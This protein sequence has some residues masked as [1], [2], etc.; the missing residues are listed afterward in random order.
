MPGSFE[1]SGSNAGERLLT[2][3]A[4]LPAAEPGQGTVGVRLRGA[5]ASSPGSAPVCGARLAAGAGQNS[6]PAT[7]AG[8]AA[9]GRDG[10]G[11]REARYVHTS[12]ASSSQ[13][14]F[15]GNTLDWC[16]VLSRRQRA[17]VLVRLADSMRKC[18]REREAKALWTC[19]R[20]FHV[21]R[22][23][24]GGHRLEPEPCNSMFCADCAGRR[25]RSLQRRL[26]SL[27]RRPGKRYWFLTLTVPNTPSLL[28]DQLDHL[29]ECFARLRRNSVWRCVKKENGEWVGVTGG[30]YSLESTYV[31]STRSWHP[32]FH[33]LLEMP[34]CHPDEWLD[35]LKAEWLR[36]TGDA[37]Y[38]HL[39]PVYGRSKRGE[40]IYRRVNLKALK[41]LVKYV[42][43]AAPFAESPELVDEFLTAFQHVRRV[44]GF[45]S[46]LGVDRDEEQD[47]GD[48]HG[49]LKC[50]CGGVHGRG[51]FTWSHQLVHV[52]ETILMADG[53]RQL[54]F[55]FA[56]ELRESRDESPPD[57]VLEAESVELDLQQRIGFSGVLPEVSDSAPRLFAA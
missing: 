52:S 20:Y 26:L 37:Q 4:E 35:A 6:R 8:V 10:T 3:T 1:H 24:Q 47:A 34:K 46:F 9:G 38:L 13:I 53:S 57:L 16:R 45:G 12:L 32:H 28:R 48:E 51:D 14:T 21:G 18:G 5:E 29:I 25:S 7:R 31:V 39:I 41:E 50:T 33:V 22:C 11:A 54:K 42:T 27:C 23:P 15:R 40:K 17:R 19:G 44:Q 30:V 55:D 49:M 56:V 43:K 2:R 36:V